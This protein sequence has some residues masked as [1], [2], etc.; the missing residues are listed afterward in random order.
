MDIRISIRQ[1]GKKRRAVETIPFTLPETPATLRGLLTAM[2]RTCAEGYNARLLAGETGVRP[3]TEGQLADMETVG[4]MAFG[5][6]YSDKPA[7]P[8]KAVSDALLAFSDGLYRVFQGSAEL[9]DLDAPLTISAGDE[10]T[11]IRLTMLA[12]SIW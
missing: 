11:L 2:A 3:L 8:D 12:G 7:D 1:L 5:V 4:K 6:V 10:F 9:T